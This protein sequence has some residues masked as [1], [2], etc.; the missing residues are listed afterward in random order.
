[1]KASVALLCLVAFANGAVVPLYGG[2]DQQFG[3]P[4]I[5]HHDHDHQVPQHQQ[6]HQVPPQGHQQ[7]TPQIYPLQSPQHQQ[8]V[9]P[10]DHQPHIPQISPHD[11]QQQIPQLHP[12]PSHQHQQPQIPPH[13]QQIPQLHPLPS[14]QQKQPQ[15]PPHD[16]QIPQ[17]HPLPSHQQK[18]PQIPPH[19]QQIPQLHPLP[20]QQKQP[21]IPPQKHIPQHRQSSPEEEHPDSQFPLPDN[22]TEQEKQIGREMLLLKQ[23]DNM[24]QHRKILLQQQLN[25]HRDPQNHQLPSS[26]AEQQQRIKEQEQQI[27]REMEVQMQLAKV[28]E[29][30]KQQLA[31]QMENPSQT[32]GQIKM[33]EK[34]I[35]REMLFALKLDKVMELEKQHLQRNIRRLQ[36]QHQDPPSPSQEQ[37]IKQ[38]EQQIQR[39]MLMVQDLQELIQRQKNQLQQHIEQKQHPYYENH[40]DSLVKLKHHISEQERQIGREML[41]QNQ[42]ETLMQHQQ[43]QLQQQI[44]QQ[45]QQTQQLL[46]PSA[47]EQEDYFTEQA[48]Q[49]G[50][51]M[52][53][54]LQLTKLMQERVQ[55]QIEQARESQ[56]EPNDV[57]HLE[58]PMEEIPQEPQ[59]FVPVLVVE[60]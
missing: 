11:H 46:P 12:L 35:G 38:L 15:I 22:M 44:E 51:E 1:M 34:I 50:R 18:Q 40:P 9:P 8:K 60:G 58:P 3:I 25:E 53:M 24:M 39:G 49:I 21:Q 5:P 27:G 57:Q 47:S 23:I 19:D 10:Q 30:Q 16:Q 14:H 26:P 31:Q 41:L 28:I 54:Q 42:L 13:D 36:A 59:V 17:L 56:Q 4:K 48:K 43:E 6:P 37:S 2:V 33:H 29:H 52:L 20:S 32:P 55:L 7:H 45:Q